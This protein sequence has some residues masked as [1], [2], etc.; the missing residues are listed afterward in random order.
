MVTWKIISRIYY[1]RVQIPIF[2]NN[3]ENTIK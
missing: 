2:F 3:K 1:N